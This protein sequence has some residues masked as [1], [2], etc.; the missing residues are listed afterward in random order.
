MEAEILEAIHA[1]AHPVWDTLFLISHGLGSAWFC[2]VFVVGTVTFHWV[3]GRRDEALMWAVI[4]IA[5]Y[6]LQL[7]LKAYFARPRP[8]LWRG[9]VFHT[10]FAFPSGHALAAATFYPLWAWYGARRW[11]SAA[12]GCWVAGALMAFYVGFG[13]LYLG[14][15]WPTDVLAGWTLGA[16]QTATAI[17][18]V[19]KRRAGGLSSNAS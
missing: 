13:R 2:A 11:P 4:G 10:S 17:A 18:I 8:A 14:V 6:L 9:P 19:Q 5:T 7:G 12:R 15:H 1:L 16:L 3:R